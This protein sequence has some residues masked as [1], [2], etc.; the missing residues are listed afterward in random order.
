M[1]KHSAIVI[2]AMVLVAADPATDTDSIKREQG[3]FQGRWGLDSVEW[4]DQKTAEFKDAQVWQFAGD[5]LTRYE[6][7]KK[8]ELARFEIQPDKKPKQI[9]F[10]PLKGGDGDER[11]RFIARTKCLYSLSD[12]ELRIAITS[13]FLP[14]T[15]EEEKRRALEWAKTRPKSLEPKEDVMVLSFK[16]DKKSD[17]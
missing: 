10:V 14:G 2:A 5:V 3:G 13:I 9:D 11:E 17:R 1:F 7:S 15:P 12:D 16:R 8:M 4:G 6:G